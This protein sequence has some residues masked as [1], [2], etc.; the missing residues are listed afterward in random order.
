MTGV[1]AGTANAVPSSGAMRAVSPRG[2]ERG[3]RRLLA[4]VF[5]GLTLGVMATAAFAC[6]AD[7]VYAPPQ[8]S[9]PAVQQPQPGSTT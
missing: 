1:S 4:I 7:D 9:S 6:G 2:R 5:A 3:M 8:N